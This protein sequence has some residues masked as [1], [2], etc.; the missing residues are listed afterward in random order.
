[1]EHPATIQLVT[2]SQ[3]QTK[4]LETPNHHSTMC[5]NPKPRPWDT[6]DTRP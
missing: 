4:T 1:M 3:G 2:L 5:E 6:P